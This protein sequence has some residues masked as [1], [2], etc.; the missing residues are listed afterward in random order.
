MG[1]LYSSSVSIR[2]IFKAL[3]DVFRQTVR[4]I[5]G[6][7]SPAS[8]IVICVHLHTVLMERDWTQRVLPLWFLC[9]LQIF[10][11]FSFWL[12]FRQQLQERQEEQ[13]AKEESLDEVKVVPRNWFCDHKKLLRPLFCNHSCWLHHLFCCFY[14]VYSLDSADMTKPRL[15]IMYKSCIFHKIP[16]IAEENQ[17]TPLVAMLI[18][19][20]KGI[21]VKYWIVFCCSMFFVISFSGKVEQTRSSSWEERQSP[22]SDQDS[23][24]IL[25]F[26]LCL[27]HIKF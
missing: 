26:P 10:Y 3:S 22:H 23:Q 14:K 21:L 19:G 24:T 20:V 6:Y 9:V 1:V 2:V 17:P 15:L 8:L 5:D 25:C 18:S 13:M 4:Q 16:L 27:S 12:M 11:S 7:C